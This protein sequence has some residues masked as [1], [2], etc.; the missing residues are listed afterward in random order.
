[1]LVLSAE[2]QKRALTMREAIDAV[3]TALIEVSSGRTNTPIRTSVPVPSVDG[4]ALFMPSLVESAGGLGVKFVSVFP[5]NKQLGKKTIHGVMVLA[6]VQTAEPL[7]LLEASYL[8]VLRTGAASGLATQYLASENAKVLGVIG[9]GA[10]SRGAISAVCTARDIQEIRLFNRNPEKA[11]RLA[12]ELE[13]LMDGRFPSV[14]VV[15]SPEEAVEG[16]DVLVTA[17]NAAQPVFKPSA[18]SPGIHINAIGSFRPDMQELP[19][20]AFVRSSKVVVESREAA[21]EETGDLLIPIQQGTFS[22]QGIYAELG[23]IV[24]GLKAPREN[25]EEITIFKSVGLAAMDVVVGKF[26]YDRALQLG[27]GQTVLL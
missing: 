3:A 26:L 22:E 5:G 1:M 24:Q 9:T 2:D 19:T 15:N 7:A 11:V 4:T 18:L 12:E 27:L 14:V 13:E 20:E 10:Q 25:A 21:L 16:A 6:D 17:T 23:E 8:T